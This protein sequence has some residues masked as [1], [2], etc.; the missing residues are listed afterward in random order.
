[1]SASGPTPRAVWVLV[2][3]QF[4]LAFSMN[5]LVTFLP[6][7]VRAVSDL[8]EAATLVWTGLIVAGAPAAASVASA[9]W[10]RLTA[11]VSP[12]LLYERGLLTHSVVIAL[13]A[14]TTSLP[15]LLGLRLVQGLM[16]G[17]STIALIIIGQV[18]RREALSAN[19]GLLQSAITTGTIV[20]P[21]VGAA[22]AAA[23]GFRAAFLSAALLVA[24]SLAF[25][26]RFLPPIPPA[27]PKAGA[28]SI[29][30]RQLAAAWL[31][32][33]AATVQIVFLPSVLPQVLAALGVAGAEAVLWAGLV[34]MAYGGSAALGAVSLRWLGPRVD[35]RRAVLAAGLVSAALQAA[36]ALP[37]GLA[38]FLVVRVAQTFVAALL[39]PLLMAEVAA[40]GR[41]GAVGALNTARFAGG[42]IAPIVATALLARADLGLLYAVIAA[43]TVAAV[44]V[45]AA[46]GPARD[47]RSLETS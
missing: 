37:A 39:M 24:A 32:S 14:A 20:G 4:G 2:G 45:F 41:G 11:R 40:T 1:M 38:S 28:P 17:I 31:V 15:L 34:V 10:G 3:A 42:A 25:C 22:V 21:P 43:M 18:S 30:R 33:L 44:G 26:H 7:Y 12:K 29:S 47:A 27:A 36:L 13:T 8:P 23:L 5:Y 46:L 6:F 35:P 9:P 16:G 19:I